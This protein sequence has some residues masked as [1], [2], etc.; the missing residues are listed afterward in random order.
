MKSRVIYFTK[1]SAAGP[2]SRYRSYQYFLFLRNEFDLVYHPLFDDI[3]I[4]KLYENKGHN[5]FKLIFYY[6]KRIFWVLR[7]LGSNNILFI[8]YELLPYFPPVFEFLLSKTNNKLVFDYDDAIFHNY[9]LNDNLFVKFLFKKKISVIAT[10]ADFIITGSPYLTSYFN[11]FNKNVIEIPTSIILKDYQLIDNLDDPS[12]VKIGWIGSNTTSVNIIEI[13][14]VFEYFLKKNTNVLFLLMGFDPNLIAYIDLPNVN[15]LKW[16][17]L[18]EKFFLNSID[19]GIMPLNYTPTNNGKCGFKLIQYMAMAKPTIS[20]PLDANV[21]INRN[22]NNLFSNS[23]L[24][25]INNIELFLDNRDAF[26]NIGNFNRG[27][28]EKYYSVESNFL[29]YVKLFSSL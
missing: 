9:D 3:Y 22:S 25:W 6:F 24:D 4:Q 13:K 8:E 20:T 10:Y 17:K 23:E 21:K 12:V 7:Y 5:I 16:D 2:S 26:A 1:Y 28:V 14:G 15:F 29:E 27:I 19:I 18:N 11:Q